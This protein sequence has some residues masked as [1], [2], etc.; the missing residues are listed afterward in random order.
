MMETRTGEIEFVASPRHYV[1]RGRPETVSVTSLVGA[2]WREVSAARLIGGM[3]ARG[4]L[5]AKY[6]GMTARD[7]AREWDRAAHE[8]CRLGSLMHAAID[9]MLAQRPPP[10]G[11]DEIAL[12]V[13]MARQF[14][15]AQGLSVAFSEL[16]IFYD[17]VCS[18]TVIPG[19]IDCLL[20]DRATGEYTL[21]DWKRSTRLERS[22]ETSDVIPGLEDS[23]FAHYSLQLSLY[24]VILR[25]CYGLN[26]TRMLIVALHPENPGGTYRVLPARDLTDV[27]RTE[28]IGRY[29]FYRA[30][31]EQN[32]RVKAQNKRMLR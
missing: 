1:V 5:A 10:A 6:P 7:I 20:L 24:T 18:D 27:A 2:A 23:K 32:A 4:T 22:F 14:L 8:A 13:D 11:A 17:N 19:S 25:D 31:A 21:V 15:A 3:R 30:R 26:V 9:C 29:N 28:L 12:E 16:A